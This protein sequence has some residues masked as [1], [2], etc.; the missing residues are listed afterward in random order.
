MFWILWARYVFSAGNHTYHEENGDYDQDYGDQ[1]YEYDPDIICADYLEPEVQ[2][3]NVE[4]DDEQNN[5]VEL[6][7]EWFAKTWYFVT[8]S[9]LTY[10]E[11]KL[12]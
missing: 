5:H 4:D 3:E 10:C 6:V 1:D 2:I 11:K 8:K 12:F 9:V 7:K